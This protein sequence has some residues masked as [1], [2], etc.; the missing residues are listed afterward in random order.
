MLRSLLLTSF[1]FLTL[2]SSAKTIVVKN[3]DELHDANKKALPGDIIILENGD[4]KDVSIKLGCHGTKE[5]PI[6]FKAREAGKVM[7]TGY[8]TLKIGGEYIIVDGLFFKNGSAGKDDVIEFRIDNRQL[9]NHCRVTNIV[10]DD[11]N[12]PK[13]VDENNW[14]AFYGKNNRLDH[15]SFIN[16][17]NLGVLLAVMLD[18]E[19]SRENFHS[20][21]HNYFGKRLP[22]AS[23]GGEIIRVGLSQHCQF[24]SNTRIINNYF[25]ECDGETEIIS[26]KSGSNE[27]KE[28]VFKRCQGAVV[29][30][31]GNDN[32]IENNIFFGDDKEG[33]G[34]IRVIN[35]GQWIINN[36]FYK[37]RGTGFRSPLSI[38]NG[39]PNS[40]A[41]RYVQVSDAVIAN[42]TFYDC[43]PLSLCEGSDTERTLP[44]VNVFVFNNNFYNKRDTN[45]YTA[46]DNTS[47]IDFIGNNIDNRMSQKTVNGFHRATFSLQKWDVIGWP[48]NPEG[49]GYSPTDSLQRSAQKR[50]GHLLQEKSGATDL[51]LFKEITAKAS[52][53]SGAGWFKTPL[54]SETSAAV[55]VNCS[56]AEAI[57]QV[58]GQH[59][60][61]IIRLTATEYHLTKP[62][63]ISNDVQFIG[64]NGV[65]KFI[66]D[67]MPAAFIISK[68]GKLTLKDLSIDGNGLHATNLIC[69]D[70]TGYSDHYQL[71][72]SGCSFQNM[73]RE[74]NFENF[75]YAYKHT[76]ADSIVIHDNS[77]VN[78]DC[79][80]FIMSDQ[81]DDKGY[82]NAEK[83]FIGHNR[84]INQ[85]GMLLNIYRG[86]TDESTLGPHVV[87]SHNLLKNC[88]AALANDPLIS[89]M[90][91]QQS[92]IFSNSFSNCSPKGTL[93]L[94]K[95]LV[96][97]RHVFKRN[98][99]LTSGHVALNKYVIS[100]GNVTR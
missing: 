98:L 61:S 75:F 77:F 58:L 69:S 16:K 11:F 49:G 100:E 91:A 44:P 9:A 1:V 34:G 85:S 39:I 46:H 31:H 13:R 29:L 26:I 2:L 88:S 68:N 23:N 41:N 97:A 15:C 17:K 81:K 79:N 90:G 22:L 7:I 56:T 42:N 21:D 83:V 12:N 64:D 5:Q 59:D 60:A 86:G 27:I 67:K 73:K 33:T 80:V 82:Y 74:N 45:L 94:Y 20:I 25:E 66:S 92:E 95:D 51:Q 14:V 89:L 4:W 37:C 96:R 3:I 87:F 63:L 48:I 43:S 76:V 78:N 24:N 71:A 52:S 19:R 53:F 55:V 84:F 35:K 99:L 57:Y 40:P 18:D 38:M 47:G 72:I 30:R 65:L 70:S 50:L 28:N 93:L 8:S 6:T 32:T 10:I 54:L 36:F 62:L